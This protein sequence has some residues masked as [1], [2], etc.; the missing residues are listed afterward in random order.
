MFFS[1]TLAGNTPVVGTGQWTVVSGAR[2]KLCAEYQSDDNIQWN[3]R[4][5]YV[6]Q[7][8]I[9]NGVCTASSDQVTIKLDAKSITCSRCRITTDLMCYESQP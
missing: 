9:S 5:T 7:W 2:W 8:T 6:L 4:E 3:S 1:A